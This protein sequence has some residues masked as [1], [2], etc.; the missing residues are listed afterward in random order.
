M[1]SAAGWMCRR[2]CS[3]DLVDSQDRDSLFQIVVPCP[4]CAVELRAFLKSGGGLWT[5]IPL[6]GL[7]PRVD[8]ISAC[9]ALLVCPRCVQALV[10]SR[11]PAKCARIWL[12][13]SWAPQ[14]Q[15]QF[16]HGPGGRPRLY[17]FRIP[18]RWSTW[19]EP[20]GPRA[21]SEM[22]PLPARRES[23]AVAP[24]ARRSRP[25][26]LRAYGEVRPHLSDR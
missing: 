10:L 21:V 12:V 18:R 22:R 19:L 16:I 13:V 17:N 24:A 15:P 26:P 20:A 2:K 1:G 6:F 23:G 8:A 9:A 14:P 11:Q 3:V 4:T 5:E 7:D 25:R